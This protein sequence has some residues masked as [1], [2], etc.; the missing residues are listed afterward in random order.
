ML[1]PYSGTFFRHHVPVAPC[2]GGEVLGVGAMV[3]TGRFDD[4]EIR[5]LNARSYEFILQQIVTGP[6]DLPSRLEVEADGAF[7][8]EIGKPSNEE[9]GHLEVNA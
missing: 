4:L 3:K 5:Q 1:A 2:S 8:I 7:A 9:M 6:A